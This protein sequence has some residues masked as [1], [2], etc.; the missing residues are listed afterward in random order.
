MVCLTTLALTHMRGVRHGAGKRQR[1]GMF[2]VREH[3]ARFLLLFVV[4][5]LTVVLISSSREIRA[6]TLWRK[7]S[8]L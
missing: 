6:P 7:G 2:S 8:C 3:R 5:S 1:V 4:K